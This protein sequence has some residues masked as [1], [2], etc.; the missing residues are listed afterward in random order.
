MNLN[1]RTILKDGSEKT[2]PV[3]YWMERDQRA[4]DN[5]ALI[6]AQETALKRHLPF[7]ILFNLA[8]CTPGNPIRQ[9]GFMLTGLEETEES[10]SRMNI[11][12]IATSGDSTTTIPRFIKDSGASLL[13][14]DFN[15]LRHVRGWKR[16]VARKIDI[17]F[18][19]IDAHNIVPCRIVS[20]KQ[21]FAAY[22]IRPKI[23]K[24][25]NEYLDEFPRLKKMKSNPLPENKNDWI[26]MKAQLSIDSGII[27]AASVNPGESEAHRIIRYFIKNRLNDYDEKRND[28]NA[29]STSGISPYLHFGQI[30]AQRIA[31]ILNSAVG[32]SKAR[33]SFLEELIIRRELS[34]NFCWY[35]KNYD[36]FDGFPDWAKS[37][38]DAHRKDEREYIYGIDDFEKGGTHDPLWNAAQNEM[39][40]NGRMHGYMRMY[41]A[42]KILEWTRAPEEAL[43]I[44][45]ALNDKYELDGRDPNGYA[46]AAWS[47]GGLHDRAWFERKIFGKIRYMN[48]NGCRRK[49]DA[50]EYI[51]R[52]GTPGE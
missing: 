32:P 4:Q 1:R 49:F 51:R 38:L 13:V 3:V 15:P 39:V 16:E 27:D 24:L 2:G 7:Y 26:K 41:W 36:S 17:P 50:E 31:L 9:Y 20:D 30:S 10:L 25:L 23:Q 21:E 34:D 19:E 47:I 11:P 52:F 44:A 22:T 37:S 12:F 43:K 5:W 42:K 48:Y 33:E 6:Y 40:R 28:P 46:G 29:G 8:P 35:N 45:L 18:H 14:T